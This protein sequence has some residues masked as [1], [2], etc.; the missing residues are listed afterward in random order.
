MD[1]LQLETRQTLRIAIPLRLIDQTL[2]VDP[3]WIL[4]L[5]RRLSHGIRRV[6]D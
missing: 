5:V 6:C 2:Q 1:P 3:A 4:M